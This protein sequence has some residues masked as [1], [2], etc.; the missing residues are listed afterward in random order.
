MQNQWDWTDSDCGFTTNVL[1]LLEVDMELDKPGEVD[2]S[3]VS[4]L[5]FPFVGV[6][7]NGTEK[8][9]SFIFLDSMFVTNENCKENNW[10]SNL[11]IKILKIY[12]ISQFD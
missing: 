6:A 11:R 8:G 2:A 12:M 9:S 4:V 7:N 10:E 5:F 3:C 1:F